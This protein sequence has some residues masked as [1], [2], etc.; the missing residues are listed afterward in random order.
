MEKIIESYILEF[1][2][3]LKNILNKLGVNDIKF[4]N[5]RLS[6]VTI[7]LADEVEDDDTKTTILENSKT[8]YSPYTNTIY[9]HKNFLNDSNL[10]FH[11][12]KRLLE[13]IST[14]SNGN[15]ITCGVSLL[16]SS[17]DKS[18]NSA[19]NDAITEN[20]ANLMLFDSS[21]EGDLYS[22]N[23]IARK[24]L[25]K[26]E[27]IV[28]MNTVVK[29]YF[30][31]DYVELQSKFDSYVEDPENSFK[32]FTEKMDRLKSISYG[33]GK[34]TENDLNL[35]A[36]IDTILIYAYANKIIKEKIIPSDLFKEHIVTSETVRSEFGFKD[37]P[38][39]SGVDK[40]YNYYISLLR[41]LKEKDMLL[42]STIKSTTK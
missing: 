26:L 21:L 19:L 4:D 23:I 39:Y 25:S 13:C 36:D 33:H 40:N 18:Y 10:R 14:K 32:N 15:M 1:A 8:F 3:D 28:G 9:I 16:N 6:E 35:A 34:Y 29:S 31:S 24:N 27:C 22:S 20:I 38:G 41:E 17:G 7:M 2:K 12:T 42:S 5:K 37:T 30:N 11:L